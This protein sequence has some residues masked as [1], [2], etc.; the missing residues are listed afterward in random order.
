[1]SKLKIACIIDDDPIFIFGLKK[2][3][4]S[5]DFA[6]EILVYKNGEDA[7]ENLIAIKNDKETL[8]EVILLDLN[9]PIMDGWQFL[10][11]F[12]QVKVDKKITVYIVS[13]SIDPLDYE[14]TKKYSHIEN[15]IIKPVQTDDLKTILKTF[16]SQN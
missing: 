16:K 4:N 7:L 5:V 2:V 10:D 12:T 11:E 3:M 6:E 8:P 13:S 1:M 9:M 14:K 15:Y